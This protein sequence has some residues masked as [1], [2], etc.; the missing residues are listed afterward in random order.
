MKKTPFLFASA[1]RLPTS[2]STQSGAEFGRITFEFE[3][4]CTADCEFYFMMVGV[5]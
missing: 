1:I 3:T 2:V 5:H 4:L